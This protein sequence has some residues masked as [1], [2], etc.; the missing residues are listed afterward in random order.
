[1]EKITINGKKLEV[2]AA[3]ERIIRRLARNNY[4]GLVDDFREGY[5]R[6]C[7][8]PA[9][10]WRGI[11]AKHFGFAVKSKAGTLSIKEKNWRA[12]HPRAY[13]AVVGNPRRINAILAKI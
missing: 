9:A 1:V 11:N 2:P 10:N 3:V 13:W 6:N 5:G 7:A 8:N 12:K 4:I